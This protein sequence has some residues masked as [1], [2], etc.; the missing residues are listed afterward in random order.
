MKRIICFIVL[1]CVAT[2]LSDVLAQERKRIPTKEEIVASGAIKDAFDKKFRFGVSYHFNWGTIQGD[3]LP[4]NYFWKPCVGFNFRLE[5]YPLP[6]VGIGAGFG[7]MQRG[8]GIK[9]RDTSGG[10]FS[11]PWVK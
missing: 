11:H 3:D 10:A 6:F 7:Y 4:E 2:S 9:N 8:A 5:Y 1:A